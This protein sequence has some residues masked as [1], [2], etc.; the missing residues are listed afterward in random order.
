[1]NRH[2][3]SPCVHAY[4]LLPLAKPVLVLYTLVSLLT[5]SCN[6]FNLYHIFLFILPDEEP[7]LLAQ[8]K[9]DMSWQALIPRGVLAW[10]VWAGTNTLA[11]PDNLARWGV[12]VNTRCRVQD[13]GYPLN[14]GHILNGCKKSLDRFRFSIIWCWHI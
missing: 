5:K 14:L 6:K 12:R 8:E 10:A 3:S 4:R 7:S 13:C 2:P 9:E 1:M 11:T